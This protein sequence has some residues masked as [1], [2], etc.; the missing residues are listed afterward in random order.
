[1]DYEELYR[2][3]VLHIEILKQALETTQEKCNFYKKEIEILK[4]KQIWN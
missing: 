4:R 2:K 1:M 3:A